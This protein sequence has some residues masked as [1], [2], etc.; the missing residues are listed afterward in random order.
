MQARGPSLMDGETLESQG[1]LCSHLQRLLKHL[2]HSSHTP[3]K[4]VVALGKLLLPSVCG[5]IYTP[6]SWV[7]NSCAG[8]RPLSKVG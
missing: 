8:N 4:R 6:E 1:G 7:Q 3:Q 2:A 5:D